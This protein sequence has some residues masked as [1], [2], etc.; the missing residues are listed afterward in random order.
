MNAENQESQR[1]A[2]DSTF[3]G[4]RI[5]KERNDVCAD[6]GGSNVDGNV[7]GD[8]ADVKLKM[9]PQRAPVTPVS[10][11]PRVSNG[12]HNEDL[13]RDVL[14]G[15]FTTLAHHTPAAKHEKIRIMIEDSI[16]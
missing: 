1:V 13:L 4:T 2:P 15:K 8:D 3:D 9:D 5:K 11:T 6:G 10:T 16:G 7:A 12:F 14:A